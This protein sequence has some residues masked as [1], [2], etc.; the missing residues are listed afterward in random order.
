[1][2]GKIESLDSF[3]AE[4]KAVAERAG[5]AF[6]P[7]TEAGTEPGISQVIYVWLAN[8]VNV[9]VEVGDAA[10]DED[11]EQWYNVTWSY[12]K[13]RRS[14]LRHLSRITLVVVEQALHPTWKSLLR[15]EGDGY[16]WHVI[17]ARGERKLQIGHK[18]SD[19]VIDLSEQAAL[20]FFG[21]PELDSTS[22]IFWEDYFEKQVVHLVSSVEWR[23]NP[24]KDTQRRAI[25]TVPGQ[26]RIE[27]YY[28]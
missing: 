10:Q 26:G 12:G 2:K 28:G 9:L 27:A 6:N 8:D 3:L 1:M 25:L 21:L 15:H 11:N 24:I 4:L 22:S 23:T 19:H 20:E 17:D 7:Q 5:V 14:S 13:D 18:L 16:I